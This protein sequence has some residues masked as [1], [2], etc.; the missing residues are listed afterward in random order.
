MNEIKYSFNIISSIIHLIKVTNSVPNYD[1]HYEFYI[2]PKLWH[3]KLSNEFLFCR[4]WKAC[5]HEGGR[6]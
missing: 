3:T 1:A 4:S 2:Y 5:M 6:A